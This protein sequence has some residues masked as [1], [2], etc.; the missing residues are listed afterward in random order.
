M[1]LNTNNSA[2]QEPQ[3][4]SQPAPQAGPSL[5][6]V[7]PNET[8]AVKYPPLT[9]GSLMHLLH[10][11]VFSYAAYEEAMSYLTLRPNTF[12]WM[13]FLQY[14]TGFFG[15]L[16]TASGAIF[17][18]AAN[19]ASLHHF[20]KLAL[21]ASGVALGA[22]VCIAYNF[23]GLLARLGL[24][25]SCL[26]IGPL[27]AVFGQQYQ[28][29]AGLWQLLLVWGVVVVPLAIAGRQAELWGI[30]IALLYSAA[31]LFLSTTYYLSSW[32]THYSYVGLVLLLCA[33]GGVY[34]YLAK[35]HAHK[36]A[37][38]WMTNRWL[39]RAML[40]GALYVITGWMCIGI[41][42][43][44]T[45]HRETIHFTV[46]TPIIYV[47]VMGGGWRW[48]RKVQPDLL[49]LTGGLF[50]AV[51]VLSFWIISSEF[52]RYFRLDDF[53]GVFLIGAILVGGI[54]A[55][56]LK[57]IT[58][59]Q[60]A[61]ER[62]RD[63]AN[64]GNVN[65]ATDTGSRQYRWE[66]LWTHLYTA[67][68]VPSAVVP[69]V[70]QPLGRPWYVSLLVGSGA[71]LAAGCLLGFCIVF[72][73]LFESILFT[74]L[75]ITGVC[76]TTFGC[77]VL[78]SRMGFA[79]QFGFAMC[80]AGS[81]ALL[82]GTVGE[83]DGEGIT[84]LALPAVLFCALYLLIDYGPYRLVAGICLL[85]SV[86]GFVY[87]LLAQASGWNFL[88]GWQRVSPSLDAHKIYETANIAMYASLCVGLAFGWALEYKWIVIKKYNDLIRPFLLA[89]LLFF[90]IQVCLSLSHR[91]LLM[92]E[93]MF[94]LVPYGELGGAAGISL[95]VFAVLL[96]RRTNVPSSIIYTLIACGALCV[97]GGW[98]IPGI[99]VALLGLVLSRYNGNY[100]AMGGIGLFLTMY[101]LWYYYSLNIS[102]MKKSLLLAAC[103]GALLIMAIFFA[104]LAKAYKQSPTIPAAAK[105]AHHA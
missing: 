7:A 43:L 78:R 74:G 90:I 66:Q 80:L 75:V 14:V 87:A 53:I 76:A 18:I 2:P 99:T 103:G 29:G 63:D 60:K 82:V 81:L 49:M 32:A 95:C 94:Y 16:L 72:A 31:W 35:F 24:L 27:L 101:L 77:F 59:W 15:V 91:F 36:S 6:N 8:L 19:W 37:F 88:F 26:L 22:G 42:Q 5:T 41:D 56:L 23:T 20:A 34:E 17:F 44:F 30:A 13:Q 1:S 40:L 96:A 98:Y 102:L 70:A 61:I 67:G 93:L 21:V 64:T 25:F 28:T 100:A 84:A 71:W 50:S 47:L 3:T 79:E 10:T 58:N 52:F 51:C 89:I 73:I 46:S 85:F 39:S 86:V 45:F 12:G 38:S 48:F 92:N 83:L 55:G 104:R 4:A 97:V 54:T 68:A 105:G 69:N 62:D 9:R 11:K 65:N 57:I 33:A